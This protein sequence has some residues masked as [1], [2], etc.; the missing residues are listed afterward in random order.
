[1]PCHISSQPHTQ[2]EKRVKKQST[3][4]R[5][6]RISAW[7]GRAGTKNERTKEEVGRDGEI[8]T[9]RDR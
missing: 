8:T 7:A 9:T 4:H 3:E 1:M 6:D 5:V 2:K